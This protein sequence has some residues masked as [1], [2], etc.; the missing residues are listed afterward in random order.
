MAP[1]MA[2]LWV[3]F[4]PDLE[5]F[6]GKFDRLMRLAS[7][8]PERAMDV[9]DVLTAGTQNTAAPFDEMLDAMLAVYDS[10]N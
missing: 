9:A 8:P 4:R 10:T 1:A 2:A 6:V 5:T 3:I 7:E